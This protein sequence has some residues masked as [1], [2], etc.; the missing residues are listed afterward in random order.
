[1]QDIGLLSGI[2]AMPLGAD[3]QPKIGAI[4]ELRKDIILDDFF[5]GFVRFVDDCDYPFRGIINRVNVESEKPY[6][7]IGSPLFVSDMFAYG[8]DGA[9]VSGA[10]GQGFV[11]VGEFNKATHMSPRY[12]EPEPSEAASITGDE[13]DDHT[14][15][16]AKETMT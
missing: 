13:T 4:Y 9:L 15:L 5:S 6:D 14:L 11:S 1:M 8:E 2:R 7:V 10:P 12:L 3:F 16:E